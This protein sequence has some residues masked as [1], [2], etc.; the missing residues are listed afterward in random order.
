MKLIIKKYLLLLLLLFIICFIIYIY[1]EKFIII[2]E[3]NDN[4]Y[5]YI[6]P[7][8]RVLY[9]DIEITKQY[10]ISDIVIT[11]HN[12]PDNNIKPY[13]F[14]NSEATLYYGKPRA[15][16]DDN[17]KA[18]VEDQN[19]VA[20]FI[21]RDEKIFNNDKIF[22]LP[23]FLNRGNNI[24]ESSPFKRDYINNE[25]NLLAA[26]IGTHSPPHRDE[27]FKILKSKD[28]T[29]DGLGAANNT[30]HIVLPD[31]KNWWDLPKIYKDYKF[32]FAME[33]TYED[34]Y[35]T[36]KIMN[37]YIGGAIPIYWGTSKIKEIFNPDSFI[38]INDYSSFEECANDIIGI[39]NDPIRLK[40]MQTAPIFLENTPYSSYY[41]TP[42]PEWVINIAKKIKKNIKKV[43][44]S[45]NFA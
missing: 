36:E 18:A 7:I 26:Y 30:K 22:Y 3:P 32:G 1:I 11:A 2:Q 42:P 4:E 15:H 34:G 35:I 24:F 9:N 29:V 31:R 23:I 8:L 6:Y 25:R 39:G 43:K 14:I 16:V 41:D 12:I 21:T 33:N 28:A 44:L 38:Y 17:Y 19:C 5:G 20:C 27:F 40:K 13:I 10:E 37:V 45:N